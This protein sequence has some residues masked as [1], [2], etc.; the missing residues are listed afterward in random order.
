[1][2]RQ[3]VIRAY[4]KVQNAD[5]MTATEVAGKYLQEYP[6][7]TLD[8]VIQDIADYKMPSILGEQV[9]LIVQAVMASEQ[10]V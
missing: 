8:K 5:E 10:E 7:G 4:M 2:V 6:H 9:K 1:M 3:E